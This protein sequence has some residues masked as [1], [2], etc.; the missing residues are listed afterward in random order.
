KSKSRID[1]FYELK[2]KATQRKVERQLQLSVKASRLGKK[3]IELKNVCK[4]YGTKKIIENFNYLF[5]AGE[6]IGIV[7]ANGVGK[8]TF[9][10]VIMG[11]EKTDSGRVEHGDTVVFGYYSQQGLDTKEDKRVIEV[12]KDIAEHIE[13]NNNTTVS[14]SQLLN[15]FLFTNEMQYAPVSKLSGGEKKRLN[16]CK[17][18]IKNPNFLVLDEPTNDLDLITLQ[19]LEDFLLQFNGCLI[20]VSHDRY[21]M[22][23][24]TEHLFIFEGE[25]KISDYWGNYSEYRDE[26][27]IKESE[28]EITEQVSKPIIN[29][30]EVVEP[31]PAQTKKITYKE[32]I[33]L[34]KLEKEIELLENK[35][36]GLS[37]FLNNGSSNHEELTQWAKQLADLDIEINQKTE[38]WLALQG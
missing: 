15:M 9:L 32:K 10:N 19:I 20:I 26:E 29:K 12:I 35:K 8:T 30:I 6:R 23:K 22:D 11:L 38:R 4:S 3:I 24:L 25:G 37:N 5:K 16:L 14:A 28:K 33:E 18:L 17:V 1:A 13:L 36:I 2:E 27:F 34:E 31:T 7:G 21:F